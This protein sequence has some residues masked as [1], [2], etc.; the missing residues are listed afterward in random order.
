MNLSKTSHDP[1]IRCPIDAVS[2]IPAPCVALSGTSRCPI[3]HPQ[4][5]FRGAATVDTPC[6]S[7]GHGGAGRR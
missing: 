4:G 1:P 7:G 5:E 2:T 3:S 6:W